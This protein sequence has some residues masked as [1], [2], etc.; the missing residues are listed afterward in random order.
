MSKIIIDM[1]SGETC[2]NDKSEVRRMIDGLAAVDGHHHE[3]YIKWQLFTK[4]PA[5]VPP[6]DHEVYDYAVK[7]ADLTYGYQTFASVFDYP[8]LNY[9]LDY[10][11][12]ALKVACR[13]YLYML[14]RNMPRDTPVYVSI[15]DVAYAP[16]LR[17][18][19]PGYELRFLYCIPEYPANQTAY[20]TLFGYNL[21][22]GISD[23]SPDLRLFGEYQP[24][25][26][27]RHMKLA[28]STGLDAGPHASTPEELGAIL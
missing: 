23:H 25:Y 4:V 16:L 9:L 19:F 12:P 13:P 22:V 28:D 14:L 6:L 27:E 3:V 10:H 18:M 20:E 5:P 26:Y 8:S 15:G 7:Y 1:G 2:H 21:S 17:E 24:L 11:P